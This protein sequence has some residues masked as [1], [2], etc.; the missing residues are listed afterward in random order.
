MA[1][2]SKIIITIANLTKLSNKSPTLQCGSLGRGYYN[3]F[4]HLA[5]LLGALD[6]LTGPLNTPFSTFH[7]ISGLECG[8]NI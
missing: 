5:Q 2:F 6:R 7:T 3:I 8:Y 1:V 4:D